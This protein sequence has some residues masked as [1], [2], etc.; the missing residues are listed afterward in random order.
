MVVIGDALLVAL[1]A[2]SHLSYWQNP[3]RTKFSQIHKN[4]LT[5][6]AGIQIAEFHIVG[7][8]CS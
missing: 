3:S 2:L 8:T 1:N 4:S 6:E 7:G 5:A